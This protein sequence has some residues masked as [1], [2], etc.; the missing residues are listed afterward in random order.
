ML[1]RMFCAGVLGL[2]SMQ[3]P[4]Q[5]EL[6][7]ATER[8]RRINPRLHPQLPQQLAREAVDH[9]CAIPQ[10]SLEPDNVITGTFRS[11]SEHDWAFLC[12][13]DGI[14]EIRTYWRGDPRDTETVGA[15]ADIRYVVPS[16]PVFWDWNSLT[17]GGTFTRRITAVSAEF[18]REQ[19]NVTLSELPAVVPSCL[20]GL[21]GCRLDVS[22]RSPT[23]PEQSAACV[24]TTRAAHTTQQCRELRQTP[25]A[26]RRRRRIRAAGSST[27]SGESAARS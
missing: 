25:P 9:E 19:F 7:T 3:F 16:S 13:G 17:F 20:R 23:R 15:E 4:S 26:S 14:S 5:D 18:I 22:Q 6:R 24:V 27:G 1:L 11:G 10:H 8:I 12:S 21:R 2:A